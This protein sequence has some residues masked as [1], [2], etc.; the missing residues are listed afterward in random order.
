M[1]SADSH[2]IPRAPCYWGSRQRSRPG[3]AY[4]AVTRCGPP[5]Q[6]VRLPDRFDALRPAPGGDGNSAPRQHRTRNPRRVI[7]RARFS[8][9]PLPL[10]T[11]H[12]ISTPAGTEMFH[13]PAS[14]PAPY[15]LQTRVTPHDGRRVPPFGNPRI[16][17]RKPAPRGISQATTSFIGPRCQGIHRTLKNQRT[18]HNTQQRTHVGHRRPHGTGPAQPTLCRAA[19]AHPPDPHPPDQRG[20][21]EGPGGGEPK[22]QKT[23][24]MLASTMQFTTNPPE[25]P[26]NRATPPKTRPRAN[27]GSRIRRRPARQRGGPEPRAHRPRTRQRATPP[28]QR[29]RGGA[30]VRPGRQEQEPPRG[31]RRPATPCSRPNRF[32]TP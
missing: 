14:P 11:T 29:L 31:P 22:Q 26:R 15:E 10:A 19:H 23:F 30:G 3:S 17:A 1:V 9:H 12:G 27:P 6:G 28:Q 7:A 8:H 24:L 4:G 13:F 21:Q 32:E 18:A 25:T 20:G 5:S 2:R 16:T